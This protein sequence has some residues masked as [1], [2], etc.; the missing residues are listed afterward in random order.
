M[1][2]FSLFQ[3]RLQEKP[4]KNAVLSLVSRNILNFLYKIGKEEILLLTFNTS[5]TLWVSEEY[6]KFHSNSL[7][8]KLGM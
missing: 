8:S 2:E 7:S 5:S 3:E 1:Y 4:A 6:H